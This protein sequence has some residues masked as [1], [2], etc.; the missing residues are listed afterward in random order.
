MIK[1]SELVNFI[2]RKKR[3]QTFENMNGRDM[4][5]H[6]QKSRKYVLK[7]NDYE[8]LNISTSYILLSAVAPVKTLKLILSITLRV[9][10]VVTQASACIRGILAVALVRH[11]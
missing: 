1:S 11:I 2:N 4:I 9:G 8:K 3:E 7:S 6:V 10:L 5:Q